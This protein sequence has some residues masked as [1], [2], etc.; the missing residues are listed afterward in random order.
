MLYYYIQV[1]S[2]FTISIL[3]YSCVLHKGDITCILNQAPLKSKT[4]VKCPTD[5]ISH[6]PS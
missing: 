6:Y 2:T 5:N 4:T 1:S 3:A